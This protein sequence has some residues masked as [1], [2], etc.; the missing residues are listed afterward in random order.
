[1]HVHPSFQSSLPPLFCQDVSSYVYRIDRRSDLGAKT[2]IAF[3]LT[4]REFQAIEQIDAVLTKFRGAKNYVPIDPLFRVT[5][6]LYLL[7]AAT[8]SRLHDKTSIPLGGSLPNCIFMS[9]RAPP[10]S[11]LYRAIR[12][13]DWIDEKERCLRKRGKPLLARLKKEGKRK[14]ERA[15]EREREREKTGVIYDCIKRKKD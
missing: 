10:A 11:I 3:F 13:R 1:M 2:S 7:S 15:S 9:F 4:G 5:L 14:I 8:W 12:S 6:N